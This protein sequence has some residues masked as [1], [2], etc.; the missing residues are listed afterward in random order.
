MSSVMSV[1]E[2]HL[3]IG[4]VQAI[5]VTEIV[6]VDEG[7]TRAVRF[8]GEPLVNG[9]PRLVLDVTLTAADKASLEVATPILQF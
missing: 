9:A 2:Q 8:F 5:V 3:T 1:T 4:N 6:A 7:F